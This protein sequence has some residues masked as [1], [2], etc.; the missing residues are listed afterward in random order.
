MAAVWLNCCHELQGVRQAEG[1]LCLQLIQPTL[2]P[3]IAVCQNSSTGCPIRQPTKL[4]PPLRCFAAG[5]N[6]TTV[7]ANTRK[8][9]RC[10]TAATSTSERM[11]PLDVQA[12]DSQAMLSVATNPRDPCF[13]AQSEAAAPNTPHVLRRTSPPLPLLQK[14]AMLLM[15]TAVALELPS[16]L[17]LQMLPAL[18]LDPELSASN[19]E[20]AQ[21][22]GDEGTDCK[23]LLIPS[24]PRPHMPPPLLPF[25]VLG[26]DVNAVA[27]ILSHLLASSLNRNVGIIFE[28]FDCGVLLD[29]AVA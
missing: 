29:I 17:L 2:Q 21:P 5:D 7:P 19:N 25:G 24:G 9:Q 16:E 1:L 23:L 6:A 26:A 14:L 22:V 10:F 8:A 11:L 13:I 20:T 27:V 3:L 12:P 28:S 4:L 15:L 18:L